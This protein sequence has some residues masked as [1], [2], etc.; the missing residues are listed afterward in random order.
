MRRTAGRV[1]HV[2]LEHV[3]SVSAVHSE[4]GSRG[5]GSRVQQVSPGSRLEL[6]SDQAFSPSPYI[7]QYPS[8]VPL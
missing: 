2:R 6:R 1:C 8:Q 4:P 5:P 3:F 7:P